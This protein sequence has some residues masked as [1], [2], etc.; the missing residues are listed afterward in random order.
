MNAAVLGFDGMPTN[1]DDW[2][3]VD[4]NDSPSDHL[5]KVCLHMEKLADADDDVPDDSSSCSSIE[6]ICKTEAS[7]DPRVRAGQ[8]SPCPFTSSAYLASAASLDVCLS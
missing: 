6:H 4:Y 8:V 7:I 5:M 1:F 2:Q 3:G